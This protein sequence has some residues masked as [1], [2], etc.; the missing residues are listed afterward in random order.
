MPQ[1]PKALQILIYHF[2]SFDLKALNK[3]RLTALPTFAGGETEA[4]GGGRDWER[5][6]GSPGS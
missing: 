1:M 2:S 6:A 5:D 3:G 4:E